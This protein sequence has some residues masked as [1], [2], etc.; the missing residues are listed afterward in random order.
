MTTSTSSDEFR[1]KK[2]GQKAGFVFAKQ[3][4]TGSNQNNWTTRENPTLTPHIS[5]ASSQKTQI[6][7]RRKW[8]LMFW[9][10]H[11]QHSPTI[12][13]LVFTVHSRAIEKPSPGLCQDSEGI[14]IVVS[15]ATAWIRLPSQ[16]VAGSACPFIAGP[17]MRVSNNSCPICISH[18]IGWCVSHMWHQ[19]EAY[20]TPP[21]PPHPPSEMRRIEFPVENDKCAG[22]CRSQ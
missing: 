4:I 9:P 22:L 15:V 5:H 20:S 13:A 3:F 17:W 12:T 6:K 19:Y 7:S 16:Y 21:P 1:K 2:K 14:T 8:A 11:M 10:N 18:I